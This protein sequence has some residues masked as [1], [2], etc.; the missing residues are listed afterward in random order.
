[1]DLKI[2]LHRPMWPFILS[3]EQ[4]R[5]G[6]GWSLTGSKGQHVWNIAPHKR[7]SSTTGKYIRKTGK[8]RRLA[9]SYGIFVTVIT[10]GS[11]LPEK[12]R[13]ASIVVRIA[14]CG[15]TEKQTFMFAQIERLI[16]RHWCPRLVWTEFCSFYQL[17]GRVNQ[18]LRKKRVDLLNSPLM[19]QLNN[20]S[21]YVEQ[22]GLGVR[23]RGSCHLLWVSSSRWIS[24][25]IPQSPVC[26]S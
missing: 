20:N 16:I 14:P 22:K 2:G 7:A 15:E 6:D 1:M 18:C 17:K 25:G 21:S 24:S 10:T 4:L 5:R 9:I 13:V 11:F 8:E 12:L 23:V 26:A 19:K 3:W